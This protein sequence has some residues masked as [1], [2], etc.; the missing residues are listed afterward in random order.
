VGSDP[1]PDRAESP[2]RARLWT[3]AGWLVHAYT[4]SG[5]VLAFLTVMAVMDGETVRALWLG[6]ATMV[7]DGT[8]RHD[9][10]LRAGEEAGPVVRPA[11]CSTTSSTTSPTRSQ[12]MVLLWSAGYQ[13]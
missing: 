10:A 8:R 5:V 9:G 3:F 1:V 7:V 13:R 6:L 12:P 11:P 4:A 2:S